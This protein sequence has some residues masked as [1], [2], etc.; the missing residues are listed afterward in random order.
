MPVYGFK[1]QKC[2]EIFSQLLSIA[3]KQEAACPACNS[4]E[5]KEDFRGYGSGSPGKPANSGGKF[6]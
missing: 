3:H 6:T 1:C 5:L 4:K 2:G